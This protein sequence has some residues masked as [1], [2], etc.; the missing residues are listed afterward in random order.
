MAKKQKTPKRKRTRVA[1]I[2]DVRMKRVRIA[3]IKR[4][5]YNPRR[6]LQRGDAEYEALRRSIDAFGYIDPLIW[7]EQTGNLVGGHQRLTILIDE[8]NAETVDVAVVSLSPSE[9]RALNIALNN[10]EGEWDDAKLAGL[11]AQLQASEGID[12]TLTGFTK[13]D[14]DARIQ[15]ALNRGGRIDDARKIENRDLETQLAVLINC[16]T[17][18]EQREIFEAMKAKGLECRVL[19]L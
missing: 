19:T 8:Y 14:I 12:E 2:G 6:T 1:T 15:T 7:N 18:A 11:L 5:A 3:Q 16:R 17:E 10:I 9:E 4:A 13:E